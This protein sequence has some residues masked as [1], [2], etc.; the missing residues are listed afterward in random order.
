MFDSL[1]VGSFLACHSSLIRVNLRK[2]MTA[3]PR[4]NYIYPE[5]INP[6]NEA[7][8]EQKILRFFP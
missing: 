1:Q 2:E 3:K 8:S 7:I 6:F 5:N 4:N